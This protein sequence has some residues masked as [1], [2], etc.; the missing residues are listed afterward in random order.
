MCPGQDFRSSSFPAS[1]CDSKSIRQSLKLCTFEDG[2]SRQRPALM[3]L[4]RPTR[5]WKSGVACR[6]TFAPREASGDT[7][8]REGVLLVHGIQPGELP[9]FHEGSEMHE[10][11]LR[12]RAHCHRAGLW[13]TPRASPFFLC[14][15]PLSP[16][17]LSAP[18]PSRS[19][20]DRSVGRASQPVSP[21]PVSADPVQE[22]VL[23]YKGSHGPWPTRGEDRDPNASEF[24]ETQP[25]CGTI[26]TIA[27]ASLSVVFPSLWENSS[28]S[29]AFCSVVHQ[30]RD[31]GTDTYPQLC[32]PI[33][34][35]KIGIRDDANMP[36]AIVCKYS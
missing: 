31:A 12:A 32:S 5:G 23:S 2:S 14:R 36:K 6:Y 26:F 10:P 9:A 1:S 3:S 29:L 8:L 27:A 16:K 15:I 18:A 19:H 25:D 11:H 30:P 13:A 22:H 24:C 17:T 35:C 7:I 20:R 34:F 28:L 4:P 33:L 21:P